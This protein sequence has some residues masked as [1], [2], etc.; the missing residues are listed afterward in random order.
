MFA[1]WRQIRPAPNML[2][3]VVYT[4]ISYD[5]ACLNSFY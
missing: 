2:N 1:K 4:K 5:I 3:D